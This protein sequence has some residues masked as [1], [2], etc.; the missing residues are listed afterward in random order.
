MAGA[1]V[2]NRV[3]RERG[4]RGARRKVPATFGRDFARQPGHPGGLQ[5]GGFQAEPD[6]RSLVRFGAAGTLAVARSH[7]TG[8]GLLISSC[9]SN[10]TFVPIAFDTRHNFS[11]RFSRSSARSRSSADAILRLGRITICVKLYPPSPLR[12]VPLAS[13][14][15]SVKSNGAP[16]AIARAF[17]V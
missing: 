8:A 12:T 1:R 5:K 17:V 6:R 7:T 14:C 2:G 4:A 9:G 11:A 16:P 3:A 10:F 15:S 13:T